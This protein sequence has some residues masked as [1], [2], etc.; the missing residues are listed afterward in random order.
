VS[1]IF[2]PLILAIPV[3]YLHIAP[4]SA[5]VPKLYLEKFVIKS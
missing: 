5:S 2:S 1:C 4:S 3:S